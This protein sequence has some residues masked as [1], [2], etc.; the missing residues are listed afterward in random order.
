[1]D[2]LFGFIIHYVGWG[3]LGAVTAYI[4]VVILLMAFSGE[5]LESGG[6]IETAFSHQYAKVGAVVGLLT[7]FVRGYRTR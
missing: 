7:G 6:G 3:A 2:R 4:G 1:M 5:S